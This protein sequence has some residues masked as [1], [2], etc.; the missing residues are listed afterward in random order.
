MNENE[1]QPKERSPAL[2]IGGMTGLML[3]A[4]PW[5]N[6]WLTLAV[7]LLFIWW[8]RNPF[9]SMVGLFYPFFFLFGCLPIVLLRVLQTLIR[10]ALEMKLGLEP[11]RLKTGSSFRYFFIPIVTVTWL[12]IYSQLPLGLAFD[13]SQ[14]SLDRMADEALANPDD[15]ERFCGRWAGLYAISHVEIIGQTVLLRTGGNMQSCYGFARVPSARSDTI[16]HSQR[17]FE[18]NVPLDANTW[19][20]LPGDRNIERPVGKRVN[21][22]WFIVYSDFFYHAFVHGK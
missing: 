3:R 20:F 19:E 13:W 1:V 22:K 17:D 11:N 16:F 14:T 4:I 8:S 18:H 15:L 12:I 2:P 7:M 6:I 10:R 9:P 5:L 21:E